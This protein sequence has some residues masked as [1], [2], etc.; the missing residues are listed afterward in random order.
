MQ[1]HAQ[2]IQIMHKLIQGGVLRL[3]PEGLPK[4]FTSAARTHG[5]GGGAIVSGIMPSNPMPASIGA[6]YPTSVCV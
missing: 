3:S 5:K 6:L 2:T 1:D 4:E